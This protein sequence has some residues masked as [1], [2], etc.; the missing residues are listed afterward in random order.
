MRNPVFVFSFVLVAVAVS[1][2]IITGDLFHWFFVAAVFFMLPRILH[3][4]GR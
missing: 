2:T 4:L 3:A 1:D